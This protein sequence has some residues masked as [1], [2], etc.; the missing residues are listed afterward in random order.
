M[1]QRNRI[2]PSPTRRLI[3]F[4]VVV[5]VIGIA[6]CFD[7]IAT[8]PNSRTIYRQRPRNHVAALPPSSQSL[9]PAPN[10]KVFI[11][12][13][14][15]IEE[16]VVESKVTGTVQITSHALA[17]FQVVGS[18]DYRGYAQN[19]TWGTQCAV[20]AYFMW[21]TSV[22]PVQTCV[23][24]N[25]G[26][27]ADTIRVKDS[28]FAK[29]GP[30]IQEETGLCG[31]AECHTYPSS[32]QVL[33]LTPLAAAL[34]YTVT[35]AFR[36]EAEMTAY[37]APYTQFR[38]STDPLTLGAFNTPRR[39]LQRAWHKGD[40]VFNQGYMTDMTGYCPNS[41]MICDIP[42]REAGIFWAKER[43]NGVEHED[44][45]AVNCS[46][47]DSLMDNLPFR[48]AIMDAMD[49]AQTSAPVTQRK[50]RVVAVVE[51]E[52]LPGTL[53]AVWIPTPNSNQCSAN[54]PLDIIT[55]SNGFGKIRAW[56]HI[57][58][59]K[60]RDQV[61]CPSDNPSD[62]PKFLKP[63]LSDTDFVYMKKMNKYYADSL[64]NTS[65]R[66]VPWYVMDKEYVY[67]LK[68]GQRASESRKKQNR[69]QWNKGRCKWVRPTKL[70]VPS[71]LH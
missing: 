71:Y 29:R 68:P 18:K 26:T 66:P 17:R 23:A 21:G 67:R 59:F 47:G 12:T 60:V 14:P 20:S 8:A 36:T 32:D 43:V 42:V 56:I 40:P 22:N 6:S 11:A 1:Q 27:W 65:W 35:P 5:S 58:P 39:F 52:P 63:G 46:V 41:I 31:G 64:S 16:I 54:F 49:S 9:P 33:T 61:V 51:S 70:Q 7:S 38:A 4:L 53:D 3:S 37:N 24:G 2:I 34:V 28:V 44:S 45:V 25:G 55:P 19:N 10:S 69:W 13:Y 48:Q 57:H 50:E 15:F 30:P 62:P